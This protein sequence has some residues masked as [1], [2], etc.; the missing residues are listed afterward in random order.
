VSFPLGFNG[1]W[2]KHL[3]GRD[4]CTFVA[5]IYDRDP[6]AVCAWVEDFSELGRNFDMPVST[7]SSGMKQKVAFGLCM[8]LDFDLYLIDEV[9]AVGDARFQEKCRRAFAERSMS[10]ALVLVSHS[11]ATVR[12][13][14]RSAACLI[15]GELFYFPD[16]E[17]GLSEYKA[18]LDS[19][20][21]V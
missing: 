20:E 19:R 21:R 11:V 6:K 16:V 8:A 17:E 18:Y 12:D 5:R 10:S 13:Y 9:T 14:C 3:S 1:G 2:E 15:D 4:N 7:Y